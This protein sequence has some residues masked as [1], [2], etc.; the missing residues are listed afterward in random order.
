M[1]TDNEITA[2]VEILGEERVEKL[3][4]R[5]VDILIERIESDFETWDRYIFYPP[6][7]EEIVA[8]AVAKAEKKIEKMYMDHMISKFKAQLGKEAKNE[9][10]ESEQ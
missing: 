8:K 5:L 7:Y 2:I 9:Q 10:K 1:K 4:D 6:D 3:K